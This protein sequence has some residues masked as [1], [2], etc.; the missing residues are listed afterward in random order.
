MTAFNERL[1]FLQSLANVAGK[2]SI[3]ERNYKWNILKNLKDMWS[4]NIFVEIK[5]IN[6]NNIE[7]LN[8]SGLLEDD[9]QSSLNEEPSSLNDQQSSD[10][11]TIKESYKF[12]NTNIER[13]RPSTSKVKRTRLIG[14]KRKN[15]TSQLLHTNQIS[16]I[17]EEPT[18]TTSILIPGRKKET[19]NKSRV[20]KPRITTV[21][22]R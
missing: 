3:E 8:T 14:L 21:N 9:Q 12:C 1:R 18:T 10:E 17:C 16:T 11:S 5:A 15:Q 19:T 6:I 13:D 22:P 4:S 2:D 20:K 7:D